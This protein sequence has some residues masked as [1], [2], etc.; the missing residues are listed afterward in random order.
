MVSST[1]LLCQAHVHVSRT[2]GSNVCGEGGEYESLTL[3]CPLFTRAR[4]VLQV[5]IGHG[6]TWCLQLSTSVP[7]HQLEQTPLV[8]DVVS[9]LQH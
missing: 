6:H 2:Y 7:N 5:L 4:L 9:S 1:L 8:F 3:D